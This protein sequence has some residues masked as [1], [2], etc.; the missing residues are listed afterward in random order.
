MSGSP[1]LRVHKDEFRRQHTEIGLAG[2]NALGYVYVLP[3][4]QEGDFYVLLGVVALL[5][6]HVEAGELGLV[7]PFQ[8]QFDLVR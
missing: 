5:L 1:W 3:A 8:L 4:F 6:G 2:D 7:H